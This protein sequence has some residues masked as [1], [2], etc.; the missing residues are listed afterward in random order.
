MEGGGREKVGTG[1]GGGGQEREG[2]WAGGRERVWGG[3]VES[4]AAQESGRGTDMR[5]TG[6]LCGKCPLGPFPCF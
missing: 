6:G 2:L 5:K 4:G 3:D 1:G